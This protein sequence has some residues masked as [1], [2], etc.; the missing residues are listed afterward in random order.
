MEQKWIAALRLARRYLPP[1][2]LAQGRNTV[3][4]QVVPPQERSKVVAQVVQ[5]QVHNTAAA[6]VL[7]VAAAHY[8]ALQAVHIVTAVG[9]LP[10]QEQ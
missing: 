10:V 2:V 7:V 6:A 3:A 9:N 4:E 8:I 1:V 5:L